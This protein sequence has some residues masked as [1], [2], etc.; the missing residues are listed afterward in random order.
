MTS[1]ELSAIIGLVLLSV[2]VAAPPTDFAGGLFMA[3]AAAFLIMAWSPPEKRRS[4]W[5]TLLTAVLFAIAAAQLHQNWAP[6][7]SIQMMMGAAGLMSKPIAEGFLAFG[8]TLT[9]E[10]SRWPAKIS[11]KLGLGNGGDDA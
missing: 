2:G 4:Y 9:T 1:A 3:V 7:W 5:L 11:E 6:E 10:M 8:S